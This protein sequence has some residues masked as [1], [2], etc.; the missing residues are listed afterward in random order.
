MI[1]RPPRSTLF[2]Y[3][4]LFRSKDRIAFESLE[5]RLEKQVKVFVATIFSCLLGNI[6]LISLD[7][8]TWLFLVVCIFPPKLNRIIPTSFPNSSGWFSRRRV[9]FQSFLGDTPCVCTKLVCEHHPLYSA[10]RDTYMKSF[11]CKTRNLVCL[12]RNL[13]YKS[14]N[15]LSN[16]KQMQIFVFNLSCF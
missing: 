15:L 11:D 13:M 4:T 1:R 5:R 3:T 2:P 6:I 7:E 12:A 14:W 9:P 16:T 8:F 10:E